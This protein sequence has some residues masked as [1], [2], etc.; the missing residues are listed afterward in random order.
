MSLPPGQPPSSRP[1]LSAEERRARLED[2]LKTIR[3]RMTIRQE[4][5]D[6]RITT[7]AAI[8]NALGMPAANAARLLTR[9]QWREGVV[10]LLEAALARLGVL[11]PDQEAP[12]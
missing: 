2:R 11:T 3:L 4:L 7:P 8:G 9:L 1:K 5:D 10:A 6:R 12:G